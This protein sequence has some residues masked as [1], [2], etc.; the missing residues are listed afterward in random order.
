VPEGEPVQIGNNYY[1]WVTFR[2]GRIVLPPQTL[3][4]YDIASGDHLLVVRGS[5]LAVALLIRGPIV[6]EAEKHPELG[7]YGRAID[8]A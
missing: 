7:V 6:K 3:E 8:G 1:C 2:E 5:G 4:L